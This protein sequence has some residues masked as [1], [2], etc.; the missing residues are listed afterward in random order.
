MEGMERIGAT[1]VTMT[2]AD[3]DAEVTAGTV[4]CG[5]E[6]VLVRVDV[7]GVFVVTRMVADRVGERTGDRGEAVGEDAVD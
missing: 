5:E 6:V 2:G 7:R 1:A 4:T 3:R